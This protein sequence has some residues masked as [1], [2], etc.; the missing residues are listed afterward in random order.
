MTAG[1]RSER[2][3]L[4]LDQRP[5]ALLGHTQVVFAPGWRTEMW[6]Y[7]PWSSGLVS[8]LISVSPLPS[9]L[10]SLPFFVAAFGLLW[11]FNTDWS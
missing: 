8:L 2:S 7:G 1:L 6:S 11:V 10:F 4:S 3:N 5:L 9:S